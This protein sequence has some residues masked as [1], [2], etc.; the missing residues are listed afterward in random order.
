MDI[1]KGDIVLPGQVDEP[2]NF[3]RVR[4][5]QECQVFHDYWLLVCHITV[6]IFDGC[7]RCVV[8]GNGFVYGYAVL[9]EEDILSHEVA[10]LSS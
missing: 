5:S 7:G 2:E 9:N 4:V 10:F 6:F 3:S 8:R 1:A